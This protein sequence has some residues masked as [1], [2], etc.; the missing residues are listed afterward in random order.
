MSAMNRWKIVTLAAFL[1][2]TLALPASAQW[3]WR[4]KTGQTQYSDLPPPHNVADSDILQRPNANSRR[5]AAAASAAS[6]ASAAPPPAARAS[7]PELEAKRKK[8]EQE[9]ADKKKAEEAKL[10]ATRADN[11]VRAKDYLRT[12]D[13]GQRIAR[14]NAKGEREI[15]DDATRA[16]EA[17]RAR[18]V[19]A[20]DCK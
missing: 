16:A 7:E 4:D 3:K 12:I 5:A 20:S 13:S 1:G 17:K 8:A 19:M 10:A 18:D 2:L 6:A 15:L 14:V 9:A 11:C